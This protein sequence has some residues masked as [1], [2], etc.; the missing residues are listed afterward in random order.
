LFQ[1]RYKS[2]LCQEDTYLLELVR[3]I[4][5][6][7]LRANIVKTR[8]ESDRYACHRAIEKAWCL[9]AIGEHFC[10]AWREDSKRHAIGTD[11]GAVSYNL[12]GVP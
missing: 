9:A 6:N 3:Y 11:K 7:P 4:H 5:L 2:I 12:M 1:N 8:K 10:K